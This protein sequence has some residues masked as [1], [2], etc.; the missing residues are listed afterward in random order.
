MTSPGGVLSTYS[1]G[2]GKSM[3]TPGMQSTTARKPEVNPSSWN[4][5]RSQAPAKLIP[6][7]PWMSGIS[8]WDFTACNRGAFSKEPGHGEGGGT[9]S[10]IQNGMVIFP[11]PE[12]LCGIRLE[13]RVQ[14]DEDGTMFSV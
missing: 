13:K 14:S 2:K 11:P 7:F 1:I 6:L 4:P 10:R 9:Y 8:F 5:Y 3:S 12:R